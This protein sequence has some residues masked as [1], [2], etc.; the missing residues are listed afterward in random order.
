[1]E[2]HIRAFL[3]ND[4]IAKKMYESGL[5]IKRKKK[6]RNF[7]QSTRFLN[8]KNNPKLNRSL[9]PLS[10]SRTES[11]REI[12]SKFK[13]LLMGSD[14]SKYSNLKKSKFCEN[15]FENWRSQNL[16]KQEEL[17]L[18]ITKKKELLEK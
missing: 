5:P 10:N 11:Q 16:N 3:E 8:K 6:K 15:K 9:G 18:N 2:R 14:Q 1:M 12:N 13:N 4:K 7:Q 17:K